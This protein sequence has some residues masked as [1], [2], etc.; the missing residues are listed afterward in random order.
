MFML[1]LRALPALY[2]GP[3]S[4]NPNNDKNAKNNSDHGLD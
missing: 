3:A 2:R 1:P 4:K